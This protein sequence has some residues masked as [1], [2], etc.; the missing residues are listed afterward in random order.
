[1]FFYKQFFLKLVTT[2]APTPTSLG[3][4]L[5]S[6]ITVSGTTINT[7]VGKSNYFDNQN[8]YWLITAPSGYIPVMTFSNFRTEANYDF[9]IIYNGLTSSAAILLN[10]S[11]TIIPAVATGSQGTMFVIF[12]SDTSVTDT[13]VTAIVTFQLFPTPAPTP[14]MLLVNKG[15]L[16]YCLGFFT[17][18]SL[19]I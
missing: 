13:G 3:C 11:G 2:P 4:S 17:F 6:A 8:C 15:F 1:M 7:N 10:R 18:D 12:T 14:C 5:P 9:F 19:R 16:D